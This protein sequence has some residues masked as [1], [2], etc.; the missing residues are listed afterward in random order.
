MEKSKPNYFKLI[1]YSVII[2]FL[3]VYLTGSSGYYENT[4]T[5]LTSEAIKEFE[6]D[7]LNGVVVDAKTY[8]EVDNKDYSNSFTKLGENINDTVILIFTDGI[9]EIKSI[10]TYLLS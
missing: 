5:I 10:F 8:I 7:V 3:V 9:S 4:N 6:D 1:I 2:L